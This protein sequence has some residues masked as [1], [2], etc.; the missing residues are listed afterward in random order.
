M[1]A[2]ADVSM[3]Q[4]QDKNGTAHKMERASAGVREGSEA[5]HM[6]TV[7]PQPT[8]DALY[9]HIPLERSPASYSKTMLNK[10]AD[11]TAST[12]TAAITGVLEASSAM[13]NKAPDT[14]LFWKKT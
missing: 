8:R 6:K 14:G 2:T 13:M 3:T 10:F 11:T 7:K 4:M 1:L 9:P 5:F 12:A